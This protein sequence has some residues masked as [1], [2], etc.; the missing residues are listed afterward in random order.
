MGPEL[1][2]L[3]IGS[4]GLGGLSGIALW[5]ER[6]AQAR[7]I[8]RTRTGWVRAGQV[9]RYGPVG[10]ASY[11][12]QPQRTYSKGAFGALGLT[13]RAVVFDGQRDTRFDVN[14]VYSAIRWI[15]LHDIPI[16]TRRIVRDQQA[17]VIHYE[18]ADVWHVAAVVLDDPR[19][20]GDQLARQINLPLVDSGS[21]R[22]DFGPAHAT[23]A[24][25]DVF[26][27]W[28]AE[29]SDTLYLAPDRLLFA[30]RDA[31]PLEAITRLDVITRD[32]ISERLPFSTDLLRVTYQ[33]ASDE[34]V[35]V[36]FLTRQA[37]RWAD[38]IT[39]RRSS[40]LMVHTGRKRK[41]A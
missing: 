23:R 18:Q 7:H 35:T 9:I 21:E 27:E 8:I 32:G 29:R 37:E 3:L 25:Q 28:A 30:Y 11:G 40:P 5:L 22:P 20:L 14:V 26:G 34:P 17:L 36:G 39:R 19:E 2:A 38:A 41:D 15:G 13:D 24:R 6:R 10:A 12:T 1:L 31:I 33:D 16:Q 4:L